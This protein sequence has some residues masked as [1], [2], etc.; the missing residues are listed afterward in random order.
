MLRGKT[1]AMDRPPVGGPGGLG[2]ELRVFLRYVARSQVT[3]ARLRDRLAE[4][5]GA[6]AVE[7]AIMVGFIAAVVVFGVTLLGSATNDKFSTV[8]FP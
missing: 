1:D 8:K 5:R 2:G 3:L 7:Y 6:T 4:Q